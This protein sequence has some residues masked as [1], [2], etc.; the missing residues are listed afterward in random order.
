[1]AESPVGYSSFTHSD[2]RTEERWVE[3]VAEGWVVHSKTT[4]LDGVIAEDLGL[5][6]LKND[7]MAWVAMTNVPISE[8]QWLASAA[9][10]ALPGVCEQMGQ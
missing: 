5:P 3:E 7:A 10:A 6:V 1:M 8:I 2:G 4:H 9:E